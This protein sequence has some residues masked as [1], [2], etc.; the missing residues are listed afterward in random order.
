MN[1]NPPR[2]PSAG[3]EVERF[4]R[5]LILGAGP[6]GAAIADA[7]IHRGHRPVVVTRSGTTLPGAEACKADMSDLDDARRAVADATIV[8]TS[9]QPEYHRWAEEFPALQASIVA[10]C[11]AASVPLMVV[12]NLYAYGMCNG[13]MSESSPMNP[14]SQKGHVRHKMWQALNEASADGSLE[15][16]AVRASDFFGPGVEGSVF[17]TRFFDP[18]AKGK[19]AQT[20]GDVAALHSITFIP[21]LAEALVRVAEDETAWGRAWHAP[22]APAVTQTEIARIAAATVG[23]QGTAKAAPA[24]ILRMLGLFV[25]PIRETVEMLYEFDHDFVVDSSAFT[26]HFG[27]QATPLE[28]SLAAV[29]AFEA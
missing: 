22:C 2:D 1:S 19:P 24:W 14:N 13:P 20:V 5:P 17:G 9:V 10:A 25:A 16:A 15:M 23:Q 3:T 18:L 29:M 26:A 12:E 4:R 21:D 27:V 6:V 7:L 8:F 11:S 28:E